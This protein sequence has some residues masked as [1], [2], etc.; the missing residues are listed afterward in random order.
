MP[1]INLI[2]RVAFN[3]W[4]IRKNANKYYQFRNFNFEKNE[5]VLTRYNEPNTT[6]SLNSFNQEF[7]LADAAEVLQHTKYLE[8]KQAKLVEEKKLD[9]EKCDFY[10]LT[11]TGDSCSKVRHTTFKEATTEATRLA[12]KMQHKVYILGVVATVDIDVE[13]NTKLN[14]K[15]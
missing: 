1:A 9:V 2:D 11:V 5:I 10:M 14:K 3:A 13:V 6:L 7:R 4:V 15:P 8:H 12:K